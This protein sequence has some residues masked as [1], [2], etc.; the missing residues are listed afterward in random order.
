MQSMNIWTGLGIVALACLLIFAKGKNAVWGGCTIGA[1]LGLVAAGVG[2]FLRGT[3]S[4]VLVGR[5][6]ICFVLLGAILEVASKLSARR[7]ESSG[8]RERGVR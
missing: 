1:V 7:R 4:W 5:V 6:T 2:R 3:F 8:M